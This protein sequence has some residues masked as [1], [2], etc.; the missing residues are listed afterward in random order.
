MKVIGLTGGIGCG[1][2][3][4]AHY[5]SELGVPIIDADTIAREIL[6]KTGAAYPSVVHAFGRSILTP[7]GQIDRGALRQKVFQAPE[8]LNKL[9]SL[10]HPIIQARILEHIQYEEKSP[11]LIV[12]IPLLFEKGS[13]CPLTRTLVVDCPRELQLSRTL[14]RDLCSKETVESMLEKQL[15]QAERRAKADDILDNSGDPEA[16]LA[17]VKQLHV[18]YTG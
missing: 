2:S 1:K 13:P 17:Q 18:F 8:A 5:F 12:V 10:T 6:M 7:D 16:L 14:Q 15:S 3:L 4:A 9:E 11:Y